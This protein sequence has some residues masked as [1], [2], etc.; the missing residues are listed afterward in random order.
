MKK[1]IRHKGSTRIHE[2]LKI[3][4]NVKYSS[5]PTIQYSYKSTVEYK[6]TITHLLSSSNVTIKV[7]KNSISNFIN[8][9]PSS[10][11]KLIIEFNTFMRITKIVIT[12]FQVENIVIQSDYL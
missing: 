11:I 12:G 2:K 5:K 8:R 6:D 3:Y 9:C 4:T 7:I 10:N 1:F